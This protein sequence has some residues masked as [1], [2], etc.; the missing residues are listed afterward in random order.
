MRPCKR[1]MKTKK[2]L[3]IGFVMDPMDKI[4]KDD[5]SLSIMLEAQ[6]RGHQIFYLEPEN[7]FTKNAVVRA[8]ARQVK[9]GAKAEFRVL[10]QKNMPLGTLDILFVRKNPPFDLSYLYMTHLLELVSPPTFI[11]NRPEGIRDANEKLYILRFPKWIPPTLV[12]KNPEEILKFQNK[13]GTDVVLKPLNLMAGKGVCLLPRK[14]LSRQ[15]IVREATKNGAKWIMAQKF[16]KSVRTRGDKRILLL[17]GKPVGQYRKSPRADEFRSNISLGGIPSKSA[18]TARE[19]QLAREV[20]G[21]LVKDGL[22]FA[23]LDVLDGYLIEVNVTSPAG[24]WEI[25]ALEGRRVEAE[26][27]DFLESR[28]PRMK[29]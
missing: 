18:L 29:R 24:I 5:T 9:A 20:G 25:N 1:H 6:R 16:L 2:H 10:K 26:T 14:S 11:I 19:L 13:I 8:R 7:I 17:N 27:V 15:A 21:Q 22:L 28:V 23:G 4:G 3:K 12:S